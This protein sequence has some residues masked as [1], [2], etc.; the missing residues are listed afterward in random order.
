ML[1][2]VFVVVLVGGV[3]G[4]VFDGMTVGQIKPR[5]KDYPGRRP[6]SWAVVEKVGGN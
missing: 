1:V 6:T 4:I 5:K 2:G 3:L